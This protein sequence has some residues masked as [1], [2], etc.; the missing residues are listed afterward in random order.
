MKKLIKQRITDLR[1]E[2][3]NL[4]NEKEK[5]PIKMQFISFQV[6]RNKRVIKE[7]KKILKS[8]INN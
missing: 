7:L 4:L 1:F 6:S 8:K 5:T 2:N 3:F